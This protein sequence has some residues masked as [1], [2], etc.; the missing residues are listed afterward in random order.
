MFAQL[1]GFTKWKVLKTAGIFYDPF[2]LLI[3]ITALCK[4]W[5]KYGQNAHVNRTRFYL[6]SFS[7][8]SDVAYWALYGIW[9]ETG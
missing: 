7:D 8:T 1:L 6:H 5:M 2:G 4:M 9:F 3:P